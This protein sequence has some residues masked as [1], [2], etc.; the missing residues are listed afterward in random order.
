MVIICHNSRYKTLRSFDLQAVEINLL[1]ETFYKLPSLFGLHVVTQGQDMAR[2][3]SQ[4][5]LNPAEVRWTVFLTLYDQLILLISRNSAMFSN[6]FFFHQ[7]TVQCFRI[8]IF[9]LNRNDLMFEIENGKKPLTRNS[10]DEKPVN[11]RSQSLPDV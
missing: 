11:K 1:H 7:G 5:Y 9:I 10:E 8:Q 6:S 2:G 3:D 4:K